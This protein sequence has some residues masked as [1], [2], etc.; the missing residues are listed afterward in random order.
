L[1]GP[2]I[3]VPILLA[4]AC[5]LFV[6]AAAPVA[7]RPAVL[8]VSPAGSDA[9]TGTLAR[10]FATLQRARDAI[11][12]IKARGLPAGGVTVQIRGGRYFMTEPLVLSPQDS[13]AA[14][15]PIAYE[16][17]RGEKPILS[18]GRPVTGWKKGAGALWTARMPA[19]VGDKGHFQ[20][21]FVG[22]IRQI[23]ARTPNFDPKHPLTGG[24]LFVRQPANWHG[25]FG[26]SVGSIHNPGDFLEY[27]I[28]IPANGD[29]LYWLY[30]AADNQPFG[31]D[32]MDGNTQVT[33]D[34]GDPVLLENLPDTGG[35]DTFKWANCARLSLTAGQHTLRWTN[36]KG[37]A[38]NLD[39]FMLCDDPAWKPVGTDN[40]QAPAGKHLVIKQCEDFSRANGK[41]MTVGGFVDKTGT[42]LYFD[43]G[44]LQS[45][46]DSPNK[47][48]HLFIYEGGLCSNAIVPITSIDENQSLLTM[49]Y[50]PGG[51][52][53]EL[54]ARFFVDNVREAL[55]SP[56]EWFL[57]RATGILTYWPPAP[58]LPSKPAALSF[59]DRLIDLR[60][61]PGEP[62]VQYVSFRGLSFEDT[63][64]TLQTQGWYYSDDAAIWLRAACHCHISGC[65]F[66]NLG[67]SGIVMVGNCC[68]NAV[69][70][71]DFAYLGAGAVTINGN[72]E[73]HHL[74]PATPGKPA[75]H[76]IISNNII[77]D[78]GVLFKHGNPIC[79]NSAEN[80]TISHNTIRDHPRMGIVL[81]AA[82]G[83][84]LIEYN[85][86][87]HNCL[88]TGDCGGIYTYDSI[89]LP[90]PNVV[91][92]NLIVDT[93]G[94]G[95]DQAGKILTP[96]YSWGIYI[97][98]E[99]SNFVVEDNVVVGDVL[100]GVFID[101]G[102]SNI[103]QNNIFMNGS[104]NQIA[105]SD[106]TKRAVGNVF[107][108]NIVIWSDPKAN[109]LWSR[110]WARDPK[111][112]D[113]DYNLYWHAGA[114][115]PE[116]ADLQH[117][118]M[119][120]HS[121]VGDPQFVDAGRD[122]FHLKLGSPA[123]KLGIASIDLTGVGA[124]R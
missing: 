74:G 54:G 101:G 68:E 83:G 80:N 13:G 38:L 72:P 79:L 31:S 29:Y 52:R 15:S 9:N 76:N 94:M 121:L 43:K 17:Y 77:R 60:S 59:L 108:R 96:F 37:G 42:K 21:L 18:G 95:T 66:A 28:D 27:K 99:S 24:W 32:K 86:L 58:G 14:G 35:W 119:D 45:W 69:T 36:V 114:P 100:G 73:N 61:A 82:C 50:P 98:G 26:S 118:G 112:I 30:Y 124:K 62:P 102:H 7:A 6:V 41:Q 48:L 12:A 11:R 70:G 88:E 25:A 46:P 2:T 93:R 39:A 120:T 65:H 8:Y 110:D 57:D 84:N 64:Y 4:L 107:K 34:G 23:C 67:G 105:Y 87:R 22:G 40:L 106:Y 53:A 51:S 109:L 47:M 75:E 117:A 97:D 33:V 123:L 71:C 5:I 111:H 19:A 1:S 113:A 49:A 78:T 55:D 56:G 16:A 3:G 81:T 10:P 104:Q 91:R 116:L 122:D 44:A 85:D 90:T 89:N 63:D 20:Q 103:I 92:G 115:I